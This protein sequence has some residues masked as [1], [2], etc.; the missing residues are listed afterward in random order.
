MIELF[1]KDCNKYILLMNNLIDNNLYFIEYNKT[2]YEFKKSF[3][4]EFIYMARHNALTYH[5]Y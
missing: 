1:N 4:I 2:K 3:I 5:F